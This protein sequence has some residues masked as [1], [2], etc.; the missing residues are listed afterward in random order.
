VR[1]LGRDRAAPSALVGGESIGRRS[2][3]NFL[4]RW[5]ISAVALALAVRLVPGLSTEGTGWTTLVVMA[6][7]LGLVNALIR[8]IV[9]LV[10]LPLT[11]VTFGVF[12]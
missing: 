7:V 8:P 9:K 2:K 1:V 6:L 11:V 3:L 10:T 4:L 12:S 5:L